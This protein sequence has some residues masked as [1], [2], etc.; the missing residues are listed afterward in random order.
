MW[1]AA[2]VRQQNTCLGTLQEILVRKQDL[3][4]GKTQIPGS[5]DAVYQH[6]WWNFQWR[7]SRQSKTRQHKARMVQTAIQMHSPQQQMIQETPGN[8]KKLIAKHE[9]AQIEG[10]RPTKYPKWGGDNEIQVSIIRQSGSKQTGS[11]TTQWHQRQN[12]VKLTQ[13]TQT[14]TPQNRDTNSEHPSHNLD[15]HIEVDTGYKPCG[16]YGSDA[17]IIV[18]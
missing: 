13:E 6:K 12:D 10:T 18:I 2:L 16:R 1:Q 11:K 9:V 15:L 3:D 8:I 17:A 5:A 14:P 4:P 7:W